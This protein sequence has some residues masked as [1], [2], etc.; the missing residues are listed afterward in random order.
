MIIPERL[1]EC[2]QPPFEQIDV[3][4]VTEKD[5]SIRRYG[6]PRFP[7]YG[8]ILSKER[9]HLTSQKQFGLLDTWIIMKVDTDW[10]R[11]R[12]RLIVVV[13]TGKVSPTLIAANFNH[14][15]T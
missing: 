1:S 12:L 15:R 13:H 10:I 14:S 8:R 5:K 9:S 3:E 2:C 7:A 11:N 6:F 4:Q